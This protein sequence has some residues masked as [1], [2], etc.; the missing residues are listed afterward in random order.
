MT[1]PNLADRDLR[2]REIVPPERLAALVKRPIAAYIEQV[3]PYGDL[4]LLGV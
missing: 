1:L 3:Y 2:Q 4:N